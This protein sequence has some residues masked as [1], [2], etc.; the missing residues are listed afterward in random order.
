MSSNL[1]VA[2][3]PVLLNA[4]RVV[5]AMPIPE[6]PSHEILADLLITVMFS[7]AEVPTLAE[8]VAEAKPKKARAKKA[9]EPVAEAAPVAEE[10][11]A[12]KPKKSRAK[13]AAEAPLPASDAEAPVA[14]EKPKKV[15]KEKVVGANIEKLTPT[16]IKLIKPIVDKLNVT[17]DKAAFLAYLNGLTPEVY[18][19]KTIYDHFVVFS[20]APV[21]DAEEERDSIVVDFQGKTY[22][23]TPEDKKVYEETSEGVHKFVGHVGMAAFA[24]MK[25][26]EL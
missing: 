4:L 20:G 13:K 16:Q 10:K 19:E 21:S 9:A 3:R 18:S 11:P 2:V 6:K 25:M 22:Y 8:N 26:P 1:A 12:E 23:V 17:L 14:E 5:D 24:D 7:P 15:K